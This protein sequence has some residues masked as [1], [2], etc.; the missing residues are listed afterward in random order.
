MNAKWAH[1]LC[2]LCGASNTEIVY[3]LTAV[4]S[5]EDV[6]GVVVRCRSCPMWFKRL[7]GPDAIPKAYPGESGDD[8]IAHG[9]LLGEAARALFR[10]A[11]GGL[12][13]NSLGVKPRLL[14]IGTGQGALLEEA[15]RLGFDAEGIEH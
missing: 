13:Y 14:D 11:L 2:P 10:Q 6:P 3:D 4:H 8:A 12:R 5:S 15:E 7:T 9:Y 1:A